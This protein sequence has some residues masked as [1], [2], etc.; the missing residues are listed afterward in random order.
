LAEWKQLG[1]HASAHPRTG[2]GNETRGVFCIELKDRSIQGGA[3]DA[4]MLQ[5][6]WS[7]VAEA[8]GEDRL[9]GDLGD[10]RKVM[11]TDAANRWVSVAAT[12]VESAAALGV[13]PHDV[14]VGIGYAQMD[15]WTVDLERAISLAT[16]AASQACE[17]GIGIV[18]RSPTDEI[19]AKRQRVI[20][21]LVANALEGAEGL[22][23]A[24]QPKVDAHSA[25]FVSSEALLRFQTE[26]T[27]LV[28]TLEVLE[29]ARAS[30]LT[31]SLD[32]WVLTRAVRTLAEL[33]TDLIP[34]YPIS[35]NI[36]AET[37]F[38]PDFAQFVGETLS[39][40]RVDP[41]LLEIEFREEEMI[42]HMNQAEE[43]I[44]SLIDLGVAVA[45][46]G[47]GRSRTTLS[48]LR[49]LR[50]TTLKL[51]RGIVHE[52][53]SD[54]SINQLAHGMLHLA[55][56]MQMETVAVGIETEEQREHLRDAGCST[57]QGFLFHK[58]M[59][60]DEM[61]HHILSCESFV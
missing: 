28:P 35:V 14:G 48:D 59:E 26:E 23:L 36:R 22:R 54:E 34:I 53:M 29:H 27:G 18:H 4:E 56:V 51:D 39:Q 21:R 38:A 55:R 58:P 24:F 9:L 45:L 1:V 50:V 3:W 19:R 41:E 10:S 61:V 32:R 12:I 13:P 42:A 52:M 25:A 57:L 7:S 30:G 37:A 2:A 46:D 20:S 60:K 15:P 31:A 17:K 44:S 6:I 47:F 33:T 8:S 43:V 5:S 16:A 49:R 11:V 40:A